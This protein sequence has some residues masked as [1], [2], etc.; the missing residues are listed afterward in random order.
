MDAWDTLVHREDGTRGRV[1][2]KATSNFRS[3][4]TVMSKPIVRSESVRAAARERQKKYFEKHGGYKALSRSYAS[5]QPEATRNAYY[6]RKY[7][8]SYAEFQ[9]KFSRQG[10]ICPIGNHPFSAKSYQGDSPVQDHSHKT[11][12][13]RMVLCSN[14]NIALGIFKDSIEEMEQAILYLKNFE[15]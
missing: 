10:G 13:N 11:G 2:V 5:R 9:A 7:G 3:E 8:I 1:S 14:H 12:K 6:R 15:E 4:T